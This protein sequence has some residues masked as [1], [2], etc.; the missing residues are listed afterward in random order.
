MKNFQSRIAVCNQKGGVGKS[1]ST[2]YLPSI[3]ISV[4]VVDL[5]SVRRVASMSQNVA[6]SDGR[7]LR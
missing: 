3:G 5:G 2:D 6:Y 7:I 4:P 1:T